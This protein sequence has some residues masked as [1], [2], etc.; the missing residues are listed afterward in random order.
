[1]LSTADTSRRDTRVCGNALLTSAWEKRRAPSDCPV[2][3]IS[4]D[5]CLAHF[6]RSELNRCGAPQKKRRLIGTLSS[7]MTHFD[8]L[9]CSLLSSHAAH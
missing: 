6:F 7:R 3:L 8:F 5:L 1:M 2:Q 9:V 4:L